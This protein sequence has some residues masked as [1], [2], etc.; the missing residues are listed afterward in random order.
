ML[1]FNLPPLILIVIDTGLRFTFKVD[2]RGRVDI[3]IA[4][5]VKLPREEFTKRTELLR[6]QFTKRTKLRREQIT[7]RWV[8]TKKSEIHLVCT[9]TKMR[10]L[11][12][13]QPHPTLF[14]KNYHKSQQ[15]KHKIKHKWGRVWPSL[16]GRGAPSRYWPWIT[17]SHKFQQCL[18]TNNKRP[19]QVSGG[20]HLWSFVALCRYFFG[21]RKKV[22]LQKKNNFHVFSF[23]PFL[24]VL[25]GETN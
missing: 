9:H 12:R 19:F 13:I 11:P 16:I 2:R 20:W 14:H 18:K 15:N 3:T 7:K 17:Q 24:I 1:R 25:L 5:R 23:S 6:K 21:L 22:A 8:T 10:D 4:K